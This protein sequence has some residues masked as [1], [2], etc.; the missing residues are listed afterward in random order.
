M[1]PIGIDRAHPGLGKQMENADKYFWELETS[2]DNQTN[3]IQVIIMSSLQIYGLDLL[4]Y[5]TGTSQLYFIRNKLPPLPQNKDDS[6][7]DYEDKV[8]GNQKILLLLMLIHVFMS[9]DEVLEGQIKK[10]IN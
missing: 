9:N 10:F 5:Q 3:F 1:L 4:E 8:K 2:I 7:E 6:S